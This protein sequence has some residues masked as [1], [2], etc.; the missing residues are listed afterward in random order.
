MVRCIDNISTGTRGAYSAEYF[1]KLGFSVVFF[2]RR[3]SHL[4]FTVDLP[5]KYDLLL[6]FGDS[7]NS[8]EC[9][10]S[11]FKDEKIKKIVRASQNFMKYSERIFFMEFGSVYEY[12]N[13]IENII[14]Y[15]TEL[16]TKIIFFLAAAVSDFYIPNNLLSINKISADSNLALNIDNEPQVPTI[17]LELYSTPKCAQ[18]IRKKLPDCFLVL[19]KLE[20]EEETLYQK[21]DKL[22]IMYNA[23]VICANLLQSRRDS[24]TIITPNSK[25]EIKKTS[26]VIEECVVSTIVSL[27]EEYILE[28]KQKR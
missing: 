24:V 1:L 12:I 2:H 8:T 26:D 28:K 14:S 17:T 23:N 3:G 9:Y 20:T 6:T 15:C 19:F 22:L 16:S 25:T 4:P 21:S 7:F 13:G 27:Y 18:F 11:F 5:S 10:S